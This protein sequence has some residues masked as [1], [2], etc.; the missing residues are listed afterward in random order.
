MGSTTSQAKGGLKQSGTVQTQA[1]EGEVSADV[2]QAEDMRAFLGGATLYYESA[3]QQYE[4]FD[5]FEDDFAGLGGACA[6]LLLPTCACAFVCEAGLVANAPCE[7][8]AS[9]QRTTTFLGGKATC[10]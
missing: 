3:L 4:C 6:P 10:P 1:R 7:P 8:L 9:G 5:V 2:L